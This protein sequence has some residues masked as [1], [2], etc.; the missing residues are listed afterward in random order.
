MLEKIDIGW[1]ERACHSLSAARH[2]MVGLMGTWQSGRWMQSNQKRMVTW[3]SSQSGLLKLDLD[4]K[5]AHVNA[6]LRQLQL[7]VGLG[8]LVP[9]CRVLSAHLW[10]LLLWLWL[11]YLWA[12]SS[13]EATFAMPDHMIGM[14]A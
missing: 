2:L 11:Q 3:Q 14:P 8:G 7:V 5:V 13:S 9:H 6:V 10:H 12:A 4:G 1:H